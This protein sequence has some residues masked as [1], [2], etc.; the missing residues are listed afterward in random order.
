MDV[1]ESAGNVELD[2]KPGKKASL[3]KFANFFI[4]KNQ[5]E[6]R[7]FLKKKI[8]NSQIKLV[9][10]IVLNFLKGRFCPNYRQLELLKRCKTFMHKLTLKST[11][12]KV[13]KTLINSLKGLHV[14]NL[15]LPLLISKLQ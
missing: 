2:I 13:K 15:L 7:I 12:N 3:R 4:K 10:E 8:T 14:I 6:R 5:I 9:V 11:S 1:C